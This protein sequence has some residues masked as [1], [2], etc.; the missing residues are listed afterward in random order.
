MAS[1]S[2]GTLT[3]DL[4][5]K[6]LGF[7]QGM[8]KAARTADK[9][10]KSIEKNVRRAGVAIGAAL[11]A[12]A[13]A[14]AAGIKSAIDYADQL[15]D[16]NQRLGVSAE[17]LSGWG[18]AAKQTG[19][20]IDALG[21]GLKKLAKNMA[22]AL[23]PKSQQANIFKALGISVTDATGNLR[24]VED[25]L[26]EIA[27]KFKE[28]D[29]AAL[30]SA[31]SMDLFGKSGTDLLD[32]LN[33][34]GDGLA[35]MRDRARE[36]GVE[37]DGNTLAAADQFNDTLADIKTVMDGLFTQMAAEL[38]PALQ[39]AAGRFL[40]LAQEGDLASNMATV[41][42]AAING[43]AGVLETYNGLVARTTIAMTLFAE[44][45]AGAWEMQK[46]LMTLGL[47][48]GS[49]ASGWER[50]ANARK[51]GQAE[52]DDL[53]LREKTGMTRQQFNNNFAGQFN[54][55]LPGANPSIFPSIPFN[56]AESAKKEKDGSSERRL[57]RFYGGGNAAGK[58]KGGKSDAER[59]AEQAARAA[60]EAADAQRQWHDSML[61]MQATLAGPLAEAQR[62]YDKNI[63]QLNEDFHAGKVVLSDYAKI[64]EIYAA[65][66]AKEVESINARKTPAEEMLAD[67]Q[68]E[69]ELLGKTRE[70]QEL[71]TAARYLG[72]EAATAQGQA[73]LAAMAQQQEAAKAMEDQIALM[74]AFRDGA[75][76]ALS[77]FVT[78]A[79]SAKEALTDFFDSM[80]DM[81]TRMIAEKWMEKM[82][83]G[84]GSSGT[85]TSGGDW[86]GGL[87]GA[88]FGG[89]S[90]GGGSSGGGLGWIGRG[91]AS[92][93]WMPANSF[94]EVNELGME[95]ASVGGRDYLLTGSRPV[96]ITPNHRLGGGA[97][98]QTNNFV[99]QGKID[100]RSQD[101]IVSDVGRKSQ[102]AI[103]RSGG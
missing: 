20:D 25:V 68:F 73:A 37:L 54:L 62:E 27:D 48:D 58:G 5:A 42:G 1:K 65:Q 92:G 33:Q 81:I 22:D 93:G 4:I 44:A 52:L 98:S 11:S 21:V 84:A 75:A 61:D 87:F 53:I 18:Y 59:Q 35:T 90:S 55:G 29:N 80:A 28:L 43:A 103:R 7:E 40:K 30:E 36:L 19:T 79:K 66:L 2:L 69:M 16:M 60:K 51:N 78:G 9:R 101:Q 13:I 8:D 85:G 57:A 102:T 74:D 64:E 82:F 88:L 47:A 15:N 63:A 23:D 67:M 70:Q 31:L 56:F 94:A 39:E 96:N 3:I 99:V 49:I 100:R 24:D 77:D 86:L 72:A 95:M 26:P 10:M 38:L 83:G 46:N 76:D 45:T 14:T 17:A 34:G 12:A 91:Y 50:A 97:F 32:F 71:L 89:G 6:T 41:F